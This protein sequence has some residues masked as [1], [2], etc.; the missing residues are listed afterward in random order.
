MLKTIE[1][2]VQ[3]GSRLTS[4]LLGYAR[5]GRY[6]LKPVDLNQLVADTSEA[7]GRTR[8]N[9][10]IRRELAP[11]LLNCEAD[12]G[13]IQQVLM[14]LFINSADAMPN[15]GNLL[16][17]T[18]NVFSDEVKARSYPA[19]LKDYVLLTIE[20]TGVGMDSKTIDRIFDP[21]FTTKELRR[22]TGLG[23]ASAY[24]IVKGHGGYIEVESEKGRGSAFRI[25]LQASVKQA[26][27][28]EKPSLPIS[29]SA[30]TVLL[31]DDEELIRDVGE[32]LLK[33]LGYKVLVSRSGA[34]AI[35]MFRASRNVI[36]LVLLDIIMPHM[37]GG[38]VYDRLKEISP[39]V[40]VLL[41]S[42]YSID[43][44]AAKIIARGC[45]GFIQKPFDMTKLAESIRAI[46]KFNSPISS[47]SEFRASEIN[48]QDQPIS[49]SAVTNRE[50][51]ERQP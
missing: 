4:Q 29:K 2:Q 18:R 21:F 3:S 37:G 14:N 1:K 11:D 9:I 49:C 13:Q 44:E 39:G 17:K 5:K 28:N 38:E 50:P 35:D 33:A 23:L 20:D 25:Y 22:G 19:N 15:G 16:I 10:A 27:P 48:K 46:L 30:G 36:D 31:V 12:Q 41:A 40:K 6:E 51:M 7:F 42:G 45:N 47:D 32:K 26:P 34:E 43:G 8:K 24:G